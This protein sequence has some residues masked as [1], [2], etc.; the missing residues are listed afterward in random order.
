MDT[1]HRAEDRKAQIMDAAERLFI[2]KGYGSTSIS[3]ILDA[4][5]IAR[6]TF[7]HHYESKEAVMEAIIDRY[8]E[9][10][11]E[12]AVAVASQPELTPMQKII[13][14]ILAA[15]ERPGN[16]AEL[17]EVLHESDNEI[18]HLRSHQKTMETMLPVLTGIAEEA[19][20][21]GVFST[22]YPE[23]A[24]RMLL[25]YSAVAFDDMSD[26]DPET[27][28]RRAMSFIHHAELLFGAEP[29]SFNFLIELLSQSDSRQEEPS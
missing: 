21:Q 2:T 3:E 23:E 7:Y 20:E 28:M 25:L 17:T 22:N 27:S 11:R 5:G 13:G 15:R 16:Q 29:G 8:A 6:G 19:I 4:V 9:L 26:A 10:I 24:F 14:V 12:R 18:F 1:N